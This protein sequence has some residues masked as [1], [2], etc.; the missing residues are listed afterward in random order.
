MCA[1]KK[2]KTVEK[3]EN[4]V[5]AP[6]DD[7]ISQRFGEYAKYIIQD[8][9][10]PDARDG[11]IPVQRR[12]LYAMSKQGN[13]SSSN[14][15]KSAK[16]V[17][18]V[19]G[20][21]HP[22]GDSSVYGAMVHLS[23]SWKYNLPLIDM[24]GNNGS[25]DDDPPAAMRYTEARLAPIAD[26]F[27]LD[28]D[29]DTVSWTPNFDDT[30]NEPT[31]LPVYFPNLLVNGA[32]GIAAGYATNIPPH[33]LQEVI[34]AAVYRINHPD[35]PLDDIMTIIKGP[36]FPT[37][38]IVQG[39][40]GIK[41]A[42][43]SGRGRVVVRAKCEISPGKSGIQQIIVTEIPYDVIKTDIV[44]KIDEIRLNRSIDGIIEVRD[45]SDRNGLRIVVDIRKECDGTQ[46]LNYL[47][48]NTDLQVY[49]N[50]NMVAIVNKRPRQLGVVDLLDAY[51]SFMQ[52]VVLARSK[53]DFA[54]K[55]ARCH[56]LQ[57][58]IKAVS[59]MDQI[60]KII[61]AS[62]NKE[63]AKNGL[64]KEFGFS[65]EQAEAIV[66]LRLYR[67]TNTDVMQL[68]DEY[69]KLVAE[70]KELAEII[71]SHTK[72]N[73]VLCGQLKQISEKY[74][75]PRK[76][77]IENEVSNIV[78]EKRDMIINEAVM[79]T[80]SK[81]GYIKRV[82]MR[83]FNSSNGDET[84]LK[85]QDELV[86]TIQ[87]DTVDT[88]L[89]FT[90]SG[91]Y[92]C[93]P[94]FQLADSK[95][96]D[97]GQ[98]LSNYAR[99]SNASK[100]MGCCLVKDFNTYAWIVVAT[101]FGQIKRT[102]LS[103][104]QLQRTSRAS[105]AIN[106]A[107]G[108]SVI[109]ARVA[110]SGDKVLLVSREGYACYYPIDQIPVTAPKGKGVRAIKLSGSDTLAAMAIVSDDDSEAVFMTAAGN[111]KRQ[112]C[113]DLIITRRAVKGLLIAKKVKNNPAAVRYAV[114]GNLNDD[115][116]LYDNDKHS[117]IQFK[118]INL[119]P[120]TSRFSNPVTKGVWYLALG[121][122][123]VRIIDIPPESADGKFE[124]LRMEV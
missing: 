34:E 27:M 61:R 87:A 10:L 64:I 73:D 79:L 56:I 49:F 83:S 57:G 93:Q 17:G 67:L 69:G 36:D 113:A 41:E 66:S 25:I 65:Q 103:Q 44:R 124:E 28:L 52:E 90:N 72:L 38:G 5:A 20:N 104:W 117:E 76:T 62:K 97:I 82:S 48:K 81:D 80:L 4:L 121:I 26:T 37:G 86:G 14:Y 105:A 122:Q 92:V 1:A 7:L 60:I 107:D 6:L 68:K 16:T 9:A 32:M 18:I 71:R 53:Y 24:H 45:E 31:V 101:S 46:I 95:W 120:S 85:E 94:V 88:L 11:L 35:C 77:V 54:A 106:L 98:H 47:Y 42:S 51:I 102:A 33:N 22:H 8:R 109:G 23:Q 114:C 91:E 59:I 39:L 99:L 118:D 29:K 40:Q 75:L 2:T 55:T 115:L 123:E 19:I 108:D 3:T 50:Y 84:G 89:A 111:A 96:K 112:K 58:L 70:N 63:D 15:R 30:E 43:Q 78:I 74:P 110:Y 21:Y 100:M 116:R 12:I 13:T 119:M